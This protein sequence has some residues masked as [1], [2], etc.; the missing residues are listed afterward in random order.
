M[1]R[2]QVL[3]VDR[4]LFR[5]CMKD[6][7]EE[8]CMGVAMYPV[9]IDPWLHFLEFE[10]RVR[11]EGEPEPVFPFDHEISNEQPLSG[12]CQVQDPDNFVHCASTSW[13]N[14]TYKRSG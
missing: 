10:T 9:F 4:A 13:I 3:E 7:L 11:V 8:G 12:P 5:E 6:A 2:V 1:S 14:G